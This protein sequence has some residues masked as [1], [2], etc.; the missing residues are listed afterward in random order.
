MEFGWL[1]LP[2]TWK[3][4]KA[5]VGTQGSWYPWVTYKWEAFFLHLEILFKKKW[6]MLVYLE[7]FLIKML[8]FIFRGDVKERETSMCGCLSH[9]PYWGPGLQPRHVPWLGIEQVTLWFSGWHSIHWAT[10]A[11]VIWS[12]FDRFFTFWWNLKQYFP[13][14]FFLIAFNKTHIFYYKI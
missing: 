10:P 1:L 14:H 2:V 11:R 4:M 6:V 12:I 7:W 13:L 5:K 8:L 9:A 3:S